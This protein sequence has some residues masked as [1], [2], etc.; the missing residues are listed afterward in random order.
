MVYEIA[1]NVETD[2]RARRTLYP[3]VGA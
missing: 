3:K 2:T 1:N